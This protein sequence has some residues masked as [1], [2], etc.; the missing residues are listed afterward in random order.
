M[1]QTDSAEVPA[2]SAPPGKHARARRSFSQAEMDSAVERVQKGLK[3]GEQLRSISA[4]LDIGEGVLRRWMQAAAGERPPIKHVKGAPKK[5]AKG[6]NGPDKH[7]LPSLQA[8]VIGRLQAGEAPT[9]VAKKT[10][11]P[12]NRVYAWRMKM[13]KEAKLAKKAA[14][15]ANGHDGSGQLVVLSR[16]PVPEVSGLVLRDAIGFLNHGA[17]DMNTRIMKGLVHIRDLDEAHLLSLLT[18]KKLRPDN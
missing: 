8:A 17:D 18:L 3:K 13:L 11:A 1:V 2:P 12:L 16:I 9:V 14:K 7:Y 15:K 6:Y 4:R 5:R 10:G